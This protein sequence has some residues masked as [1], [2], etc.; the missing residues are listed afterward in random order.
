MERA[1]RGS[2]IT[3]VLHM[4]RNVCSHVSFARELLVLL[5]NNYTLERKTAEGREPH[6][7]HNHLYEISWISEAENP[8][9]VRLLLRKLWTL[10]LSPGSRHRQHPLGQRCADSDSRA[11][12]HS[13]DKEQDC[14]VDSTV[15]VEPVRGQKSLVF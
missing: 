9:D 1:W 8:T 15:Y 10:A 4:N 11:F 2:G 14:E 13:V 6:K 12:Y 3:S 5:S 7:K